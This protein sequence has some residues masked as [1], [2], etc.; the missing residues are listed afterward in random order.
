M[1]ETRYLLIGGGLAAHRAARTLRQRDPEG[2]VL[3]VS[4]E[5]YPPYDRPPLSK[6]LLRGERQAEQCV[7]ERAEALRDAGVELELG[8]R[9][10]GL[11]PEQRLAILQGGERVRFERALLATGG[12]PIPLRVPGA[13][14]EGVFCLRT[15][16]DAL[17]IRAAAQAARRAVVVGAGFIG[18]ELASSLVALGLEVT[19]VEARPRIWAHFCPEPASAFFR[20]HAEQR[21]V[22]FVLG[23]TVQRL[24]GA[25]GRVCAAVT[26]RGERL[27]CE[28]VCV[29]IGIRP[30]IEL[31]ERAGLELEDGVVV[32]ARMRTSHQA[33]WAAG[34][35][36]RY[37]D[38][39]FGRRRRVEHWGHAEHCGQIA[40][41]NM[42]GG[43]QDYALLSYVWS[44]L[45][46]LHLEFAG[47]ESEYDRTLVRGSLEQP[48]FTLLYLKGD[49][50]QAYLA[51]NASPRSF[52]PLRKLIQRRVCLA[53]RE[54]QLAD[55]EFELRELL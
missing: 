12:R 55:P 11:E 37:P 45:F 10:E 47:D 8:R 39:V 30:A 9:V 5:P 34:D 49:V 17:A 41:I 20:R 38:P 51:V 3:L 52:G 48:P 2:A 27:E 23:T 22:R 13:E 54:R 26:A 36:V 44:D 42:A 53:G 14:L 1:R 4:E 7:Y 46:D 28:M 24:L 16:E 31:A 43:A 29:G 19:V 18:M 6:E 40:A 21:G 25:G 33:V 15:L 35:I 50:L 32:D